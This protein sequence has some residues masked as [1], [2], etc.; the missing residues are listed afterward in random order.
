M[1]LNYDVVVI[2]GGSAGIAAALS[3]SR[4]GAKTLLV[5]REASLGGQ[6]VTAKVASYCGFYTRGQAPDLAVGGVAKEVLDRMK[7]AGI[8]VTPRPSTAT[9][10]VSIKF[11]VETMKIIFDEMVEDSDLD[12]LYHTSLI[13]VK[14]ENK[15]IVSVRL[16][17][18]ADQYDVYAKTF[19]DATGNGN[20]THLAGL[21]MDWGNEGGNVQQSS[22]VMT[23]NNLPKRIITLTEIQEAISKAKAAGVEPLDVKKGMIFKREEA[24]NGMCL[25]PSTTITSLKGSELTKQEIYL[26]KQARAIMTVINKYI[27]GCEEAQ[28]VETGPN[29]GFREARRMHGDESLLGIDILKAKKREDSVGRAAWSPELHLNGT[30]K[31]EHIPDNDYASIPLSILHSRDLSN[32]WGGGRLVSSDSTGLGS[33]RVMG[34]SFVTGQAAGV[35]ASQQ[36]LTGIYEVKDVQDVLKEQNALL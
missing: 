34:T 13:G 22:L 17:D 14:T 6:A 20:L 19:V 31:Y 32:L 18:D 3:S 1:K 7:Q 12:F 16:A 26:R 5:E 24:T 4:N 30:F 35:A 27:A 36:A 25:I 28:L 8:D 23:L 15:Q 33:L 10:N 9:G 21:K 29:I 2:G 11:D